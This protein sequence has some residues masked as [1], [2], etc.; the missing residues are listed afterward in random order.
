M[1]RERL[2]Y[3]EILARRGMYRRPPKAE[4]TADRR[5]GPLTGEDPSLERALAI[6]QKVLGAEHPAAAASL[7]KLAVLLRT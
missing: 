7:Q 3:N 2:D 4:A 5:G 1:T 6:R